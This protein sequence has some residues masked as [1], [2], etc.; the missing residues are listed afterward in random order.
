MIP[1]WQSL[2]TAPKDGTHILFYYEGRVY[3]AWYEEYEGSY[4]HIDS[5]CSN[6]WY[7]IYDPNP[8]GSLWSPIIYPEIS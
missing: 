5:P 1:D 7:D 6:F 3:T 2:E 8:S 4:W